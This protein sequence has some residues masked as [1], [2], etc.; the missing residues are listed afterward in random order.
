MGI[1]AKIRRDENYNHKTGGITMGIP[2]KVE[3]REGIILNEVELSSTAPDV[4]RFSVEGQDWENINEMGEPGAMI[5]VAIKEYLR[6]DRDVKFNSEPHPDGRPVQ[7]ATRVEWRVPP[8]L[9]SRM[10]WG[11]HTGGHIR[12]AISR[13]LRRNGYPKP[14]FQLPP[15]QKSSPEPIQ[16]TVRETVWDRLNALGGS[17]SKH[18]ETAVKDYYATGARN[19]FDKRQPHETAVSFWWDPEPNDMCKYIPHRSSL[20]S[21]DFSLWCDAAIEHYLAKH[22]G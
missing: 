3:E 6:R 1:L 21:K 2:S 12:S 5:A 13:F 15:P 4:L 18:F 8:D 11:R 7:S 17:R 9:R 22:G 16:V 19:T 20:P 10:S 14:E